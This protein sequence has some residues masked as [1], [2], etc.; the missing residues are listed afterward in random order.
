M[1][2][3]VAGPRAG[4]PRCRLAEGVLISD[5]QCWCTCVVERLV[6]PTTLQGAWRSDRSNASAPLRPFQHSQTSRQLLP[7]SHLKYSSAEPQLSSGWATVQSQTNALPVTLLRTLRISRWTRGASVGKRGGVQI[8]SVG[9]KLRP[10]IAGPA[11]ITHEDRML[12]HMQARALGAL[13]DGPGRA[14]GRAIPGSAE[15]VAGPAV[16]RTH[17]MSQ[18]LPTT[19]I[20]APV[21]DPV[22]IGRSSSK[23]PAR[24]FGV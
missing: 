22:I 5:L 23:P 10:A 20:R 12:E 21:P 24:R 19:Q 18:Q 6:I 3:S 8:V 15:L 9:G 16:R 2:W 14:P 17:I 11:G 7:S 13:G 1:R 4:G